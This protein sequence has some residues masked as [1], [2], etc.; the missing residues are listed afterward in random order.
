MNNNDILR[1]LRYT[2]DY[3]DSEMM[4]IFAKA[5]DTVSRAVISDWL[6]KEEDEAFV[7]IKDVELA[8]FLNGF[9]ILHR[10]KRDGPQPVAERHLSNNQILRKVKIAL[11][12][13]DTDMVDIMKLAG[14]TVSRHEISAFFRKEEQNQYRPCLDQFLRNFFQGLQAKHRPKA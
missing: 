11:Q 13:K 3:S 9:I 4:D 1:R 8:T 2:F 12:L 10:G 7:E 5:G 6:K 14:T